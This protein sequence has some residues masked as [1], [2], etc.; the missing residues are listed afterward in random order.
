MEEDSL[1]TETFSCKGFTTSTSKTLLD[2]LCYYED[3]YESRL[4]TPIHLLPWL[5]KEDINDKC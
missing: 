1:P 2:V 3:A 4:L 5:E